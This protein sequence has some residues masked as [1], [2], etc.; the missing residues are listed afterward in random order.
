[1]RVYF[2]REKK[3]FNN[4]TFTAP[5][6]LFPVF[7]IPPCMHACATAEP[8]YVSRHVKALT[9]LIHTWGFRIWPP[10]DLKVIF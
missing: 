6:P 9:R 2:A 4:N 8:L 3:R 10:I 5:R 7:H 1:M